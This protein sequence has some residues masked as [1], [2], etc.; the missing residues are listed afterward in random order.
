M[1]KIL[2]QVLRDEVQKVF[3]DMI[4]DGTAK[5]ISLKW[6]GADLIKYGR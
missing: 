4:K 2:R 1:R 5:K 3:G 6:F